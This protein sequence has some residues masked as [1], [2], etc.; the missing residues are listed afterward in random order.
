[1]KLTEAVQILTENYSD[2]ER[3]FPDV[4]NMSRFFDNNNNDAHVMI[5]KSHIEEFKQLA[6]DGL[7]DPSDRDISQWIGMAN[8]V[9]TREEADEFFR[10][11]VMAIGRANDKL[12]DYEDIYKD[13]T[14]EII[15]LENYAAAKKLCSGMQLCIRSS[16]EDFEK[17]DNDGVLFLIKTRKNNYVYEY[18]KFN[19]DGGLWDRGNQE[20]DIEKFVEEE[21]PFDINSMTD[22]YYKAFDNQIDEDAFDSLLTDIET[23]S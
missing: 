13:N 23:Y 19:E 7:V 14:I 11:F 21:G 16:E 17:Y 3:I 1:M 20:V 18:D 6:K 2:A 8:R 15:K 22:R 10:E 9:E 5:A 4:Y 12:P